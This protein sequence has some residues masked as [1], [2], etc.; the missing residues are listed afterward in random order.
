MEKLPSN[1]NEENEINL[2]SIDKLDI[3][4]DLVY[5]KVSQTHH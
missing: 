2:V 1:S 5:D 3:L 4:F